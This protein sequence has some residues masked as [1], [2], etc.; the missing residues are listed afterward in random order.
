MCCDQLLCA[1]CA[2]PV[3]E[4]R[5]PVCRV[6]RSELHAGVSTHLATVLAAALLLLAVLALLADRF[7][8]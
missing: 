1:H 5:C 4:A 3:A 6:A 2:H 8:G 7:S